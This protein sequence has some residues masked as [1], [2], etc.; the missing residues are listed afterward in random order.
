M[1]YVFPPNLNENAWTSAPS[2]L[3][4]Q[5]IVSYLNLLVLFLLTRSAFLK[6]MNISTTVLF[7]RSYNTLNLMEDLKLLYR[8][9]GLQGK[10]IC[11]LFTDNE[12]KDESFLEYLNNVLSSG[13]VRCLLMIIFLLL[14]F[15]NS[16]VK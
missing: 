10:G 14:K 5:E 12:I 15:Y 11:F 1:S 8:T 13:E 16:E 4:I 3:K 9:A 6:G 7:C 2:C